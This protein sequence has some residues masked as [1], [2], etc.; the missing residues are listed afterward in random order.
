MR[1]VCFP[2][3]FFAS[4][5]VIEENRCFILTQT[6]PSRHAASGHRKKPMS[7]PVLTRAQSLL[8]GGDSHGAAL[9]L[10]SW[11]QSE[12]LEVAAL[13]EAATLLMLCDWLPQAQTT[14]ERALAL[15][16]DYPHLAWLYAG[17]LM[18]RQG[19]GRHPAVLEAY[20]R[21]LFSEPDN[22]YLMI[23]TADV[24]RTFE[25]Y[26]QAGELYGQAFAA[27]PDRALKVEAEFKRGCV[28]L[29]QGNT[30]EAQA[31]FGQV[32]KMSPDHEEALLLFRSGDGE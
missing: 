5:N 15:E 17:I 30:V 2:A 9:C 29:A 1:A 4:R 10:T 27:A 3:Y 25:H 23:E 19:E 22:P 16:A 28:L 18:R 11:L 14:A 32:L 13:F 26:E 6:L 7:E 21:A 20:H 8:A 31:A 12:A 24:E